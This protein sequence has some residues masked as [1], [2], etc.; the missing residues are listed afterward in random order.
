MAKPP[1]LTTNSQTNSG[2]DPE[3]EDQFEVE[4]CW[5][6]QQLEISLG[7]SKLPEKQAESMVKAINV[8]KSNSVP[9]IKKRMLMRNTLG[10]YR[11]KMK[12]DEKKFGKSAIEFKLTGKKDS[13]SVF[14]K[15]ACA[16]Q[17]KETVEKSTKSNSSLNQSNSNDESNEPFK[18]NFQLSDE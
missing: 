13:S 12:D 3:I 1:Q 16:L 5:C 4:L 17:N 8:L 15:K 18:F 14:I 2:L 7:T 9:F 10:D 11:Q 6:I